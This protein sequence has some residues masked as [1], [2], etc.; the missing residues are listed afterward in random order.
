MWQT[1]KDIRKLGADK[2]LVK[3]TILFIMLFWSQFAVLMIIA[4]IFDLDTGNSLYGL[5]SV[6]VLFVSIVV[7][8]L[9]I[10]RAYRD[11]HPILE[12]LWFPVA[13][14]VVALAIAWGAFVYSLVTGGEFA[15][16]TM[17]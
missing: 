15:S 16:G 10:I 17:P 8:L 3:K 14:I 7:F 4:R 11:K 9:R 6:S 1:F 5:I 13:M 12:K 2:F